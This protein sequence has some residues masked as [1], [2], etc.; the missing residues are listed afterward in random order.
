[1]TGPN[2]VFMMAD[3]LGYGDLS[4]FGSSEID[5]PNIDALGE[6]GVTF[7][8]FHSN[9][10][11]C[12]PTRAS[13]I[14]GR[15]AQ[16]ANLEGV[17]TAAGPSREHGLDP[18]KHYSL[19]RGLQDAGYRTAVFGKWHL[20]YD[21]KYNPV[22]H[23]FNEFRGYVSGNVDYHSHVDNNGVKDWWHNLEQ[24][25]EEGYVTD[26]ISRHAV[27]FI[28][29][30]DDRP[31]FVYVAHEA[32]HWPYQGRFDK[33]DRMPGGRPTEDFP[34]RGSRQDQK[35][36]YKEMI[37]AMDEGL[38]WIMDA[39][40]SKGIEENTLV[41]F[42]SDN[43]PVPEVG[44]AGGL[45]G[46]KGDVYEGGHRV[47]ALASWE[48]VIAPGSRIDEPILTMDVLPSFLSL[49]SSGMPAEAAPEAVDGRDFS[50]LLRNP[51][52]ETAET[53]RERSC[54]WRFKGRVAV[55]QNDWKLVETSDRSELFNLAQDRGETQNLAPPAEEDATAPVPDRERDGG[56]TDHEIRAAFESL[57]AAS[58]SWQAGL[59]GV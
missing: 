44:S 1:M 3:D 55:R 32:P 31:F 41:F 39:I 13:L 45:K 4:S 20:G 57:K 18:A 21:T 30:T 48:G 11:V 56:P 28:E 6:R 37:E 12:T 40:R 8:D 54:F 23:G 27:D 50:E 51:G 49:S 14:T 35:A 15:Y 7:G 17:L 43:G 2:I 34:P 47:P 10:P 9:G 38:G 59:P 19:V 29:E 53:F 36:A 52:S 16:R 25:D 5:T 22:H 24:T 33:A 26:L 42:C 58:R 46:V